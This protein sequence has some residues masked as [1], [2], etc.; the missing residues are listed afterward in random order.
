M[1]GVGLSL[2][3]APA[4]PSPRTPP[5]PPRPSPPP[6]SP[7]PPARPFDTQT[8]LRTSGTCTVI[9]SQDECQAYAA[10]R[11]WTFGINDILF[12]DCAEVAFSV[13][14][15]TNGCI[16]N[17]F[18]QQIFYVTANCDTDCAADNQCACAQAPAPPPP[19]PPPP[20]PPPWPPPP[21]P[22]P[23]P[24]P[25]V[26]P[27]GP[28]P[29]S[30]PVPPSP[31]P[32]PPPPPAAPLDVRYVIN[33]DFVSCD[34]SCAAVERLCLPTILSTLTI[35]APA[36]VIDAFARAGVVCDAVDRSCELVCAYDSM[37]RPY[38]C[39]NKCAEWGAPCR[40][41]VASSQAQPCQT[42]AMQR[43]CP[44]GLPSPSPPPPSPPPRPL[45]PPP[46]TEPSP[47]PPLLPA[48]PAP[49]EPPVEFPME[50]IAVSAVAMSLL[51]FLVGCCVAVIVGQCTERRPR[52][53]PASQAPPVAPPLYY[54]QVPGF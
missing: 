25:S 52:A 42:V 11:N 19:S 51:L 39:E 22:P 24:P 38:D 26:P 17:T 6:P 21:L 49:P 46:P 44:C 32:T 16:W 48:S 18:F 28:P 50:W 20:S 47:P 40:S 14:N 34:A 29:L 41:C 3:A 5:P 23:P 35:G 54:A 9:M 27:L 45:D 33:P 4:P 13:S 12:A 36:T 1:L 8:P 10:A 43:L 53:A 37:G 30:P 31:P 7:L 2:G 15:A